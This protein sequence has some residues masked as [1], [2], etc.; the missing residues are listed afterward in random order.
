MHSLRKL[1]RLGQRL[2]DAWRKSTK[3]RDDFEFH[4]GNASR[5]WT[6]LLALKRQLEMAHD[7]GFRHC[8]A[9]LHEDY[10]W[11]LDELTGMIQSLR[12]FRGSPPREPSL[13]D[14][15]HELRALE[16]DFGEIVIDAKRSIL[17]VTTEPITLQGVYL[18]PF[19]IDFGW[20]RLGEYRGVRCFDIVARDPHPAN[21]RDDVTHPHVDDGN[22]CAGDATA[23]IDRALSEGRISDAF[24]LIRSVLTTYNAKSAYV[25]LAEW[26]GVSCEDCR[27]RVQR[28]NASYC[29]GCEHDLCEDCASSCRSCDT[30]RC[31]DCLTA[32]DGCDELCC[33]RCLEEIESCK[34]LF[35]MSR[36]LQRLFDRDAAI[37]SQRERPLRNLLRGRRRNPTHPDPRGILMPRD[38]DS[39]RLI[40]T[41]RAWLKWQFLCHAGPTEIGAFGLSNE[42]APLVVEDLL[43]VKQATTSVSVAFDDIA[44]ADLFDDMADAGIPP[45]RFARIWL[46]T[47]P[48]ASATPSGL[49]ETFRRVFGGCDWAV[50]GILAGC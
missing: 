50:M 35:L 41:P 23:P 46:H 27:N 28:E 43:V 4:W 49:D 33:S 2:H 19:A 14:W 45:N 8:L 32:C 47:H 26:D 1:L 18:G 39:P 16:D 30:T 6:N 13:S 11:R 36:H 44:V 34:S 29:S 25:P 31:S 17:R 24:L 10:R 40:F 12:Q 21:N 3:Q 42:N 20:S 22:L 38:P 48:G 15:F 5:T 37:R 9:S 7:R